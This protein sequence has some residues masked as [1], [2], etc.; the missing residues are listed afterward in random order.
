MQTENPGQQSN[1][2]ARGPSAEY[3]ENI[4][5]CVLMFGKS[6]FAK[7]VAGALFVQEKASLPSSSCAEC[8]LHR[9][10]KQLKK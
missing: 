2:T 10:A 5:E 8:E 6:Y 9:P 7:N 4:T 1:V 3:Q